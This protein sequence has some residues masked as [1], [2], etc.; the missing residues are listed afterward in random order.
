L[1]L[2]ST[3]GVILSID[4]HDSKEYDANKKAAMHDLEKIIGLQKPHGLLQQVIAVCG[5]K[6]FTAEQLISSIKKGD[7]YGK[8]LVQ[9]YQLKKE[10]EAELLKKSKQISQT[11]DWGMES[12]SE[13]KKSSKDI[14]KDSI[15]P[16]LLLIS[17]NKDSTPLSLPADC[18]TFVTH[19]SH[20][21]ADA[22]RL[23]AQNLRV[24]EMILLDGDNATRDKVETYLKD[25]NQNI[26]LIL[27]YDHGELNVIYGQKDG[28]RQGVI[29]LN[30]VGL[31]K[32][33]KLSTVSCS[34]AAVLG[35]EACRNGA[36]AY[37]GYSEPI[38]E[39]G[40][41]SN[42]QTDQLVLNKFIESFNAANLALLNGK[43]FQ[44]SYD[45]GKRV[46]NQKYHELMEIAKE[47]PDKLEGL[48]I[49]LDA[50]FLLGDSTW[51]K[52]H[53]D[54]NTRAFQGQ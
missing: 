40:T 24:W 3:I 17:P 34:S 18:S 30:N 16:R 20:P 49:F 15:D 10:L 4:I 21:A 32:G 53:G 36:I 8:Q 13:K 38:W 42:S 43:T 39:P 48:T 28:Q 22:V 26:D 41:G 33:K 27:H 45:Q 2:L 7:Q 37:L 46:F 44:E 1:T 29:D 12:D 35:E 31:L 19:F 9:M 25:G 11:S 14:I 51:L 5:D 52:G 47:A 6:Q 50:L 23:A 54:P